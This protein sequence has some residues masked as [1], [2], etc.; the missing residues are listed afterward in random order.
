M[1]TN[2]LLVLVCTYD[3]I[4]F[5]DEQ[6]RN[7]AKKHFDHTTRSGEALAVVIQFVAEWKIAQRLIHLQLLTKSMTGEEIGRELV[8]RLLACM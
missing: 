6:K 8:D 2:L 1:H 5:A 7:K 3:L 4:P